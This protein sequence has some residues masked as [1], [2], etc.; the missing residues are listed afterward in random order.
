MAEQPPGQTPVDIPPSAPD[1][2]HA[3]QALLPPATVQQPAQGPVPS[4]RP[5][6][7]QLQARTPAVTGR[8]PPVETGPRDTAL[9]SS[10]L[11]LASILGR[12]QRDESEEGVEGGEADSRAPD[13]PA[14]RPSHKRRRRGSM[15]AELS[16]QEPSGGASRAV[17]NGSRAAEGESAGASSSAMHA[18]HPGAV[19]TVR[20]NGAPAG[21][22]RP[23]YFGHSREEVTRI[24]IQALNDLGYHAAA[25]SVSDESGFQVESPDVVAFRQAVLSGSWARAEELLCGKAAA[26]HGQASGNGL[27]LAPGADRNRMRFQL[28]EQKFLELLER[29][30]TSRALAVLRNELTPLCAEQHQTLHLLSR[31]LMCQD[32]E[33][34]RLRA[35]WD[36][37]D[38]QSR[39]VLLAQ[40]SG[41]SSRTSRQAI[42]VTRYRTADT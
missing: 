13:T 33:D 15:Q 14:S 32:A 20:A 37:A 4:T 38:G 39:H 19:H 23:D 12:R 3:L 24:L 9:S 16:S 30:E 35:N 2:R 34:L 21:L 22:R 25:D 31:L 8:S 42:C 10:S 1:R 11:P 6:P 17:S 27:V 41:Q 7:L 18:T 36:G 26:G 5:P 29:R 28:R 40:L